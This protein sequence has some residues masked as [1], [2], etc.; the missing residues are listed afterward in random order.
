MP[1]HNTFRQTAIHQFITHVTH[2]Q[3]SLPETASTPHKD[4]YDQTSHEEKPQSGSSDLAMTRKRY[5]H[6]GNQMSIVHV[7][8]PEPL[9]P[10]GVQKFRKTLLLY[11][12]QPVLRKNIMITRIKTAI[13]LQY[14]RLTTLLCH[15]TQ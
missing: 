4:S 15:H 10:A 5:S 3:L 7:R 14:Y 6:S 8:S 11:V 12:S 13:T 1:V 9:L 2:R